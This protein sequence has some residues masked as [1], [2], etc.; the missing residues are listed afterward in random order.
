MKK[1]LIL[2]ITALLMITVASFAKEIISENDLAEMTAEQGVSVSLNNIN[3]GSVY[4]ETISWGDSDGSDA[5]SS[6]Y[7]SAGYGGM[8]AANITGPLASF[9]GDMTV[10]VGSSGTST[11]AQI[12]MPTITV[13][14]LDFSTRLKISPNLN[15]VEGSS[16]QE[17]QRTLGRV[18]MREFTTKVQ[19]VVQIYA[20]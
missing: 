12:V 14:N 4:I 18:D 19:G 8:R 15:L 9:N 10:D 16:A 13:G 20:H 17:N 6:A 11:K 2:A 7:S 1:I 5:F 3:T